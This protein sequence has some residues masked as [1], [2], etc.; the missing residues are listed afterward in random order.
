MTK[1]SDRA[2]DP[3]ILSNKYLM[4]CVIAR[5]ARQLSEKKGRLNLEEGEL[6]FNPIQQA[7][8]EIE[9]GKIIVEIPAAGPAPAQEG[10]QNDIRGVEKGS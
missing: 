7:I 10:D 1:K 5:R 9:E 6:Y 8:R 4:A 2:N 3:S